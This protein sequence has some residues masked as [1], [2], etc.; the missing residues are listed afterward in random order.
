MTEPE[1]RAKSKEKIDELK[2][3]ANKLQVH[4]SAENAISNNIIRPTIF[5]TDMEEYDIEKPKISMTPH[6]NRAEGMGVHISKPE[7]KDENTNTDLPK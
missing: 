4:I 1:A 7:T 3:L 2:A 6:Q 5:F